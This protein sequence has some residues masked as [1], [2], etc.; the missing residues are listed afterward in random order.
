MDDRNE[1]NTKVIVLNDK[2]IVE[3][4]FKEEYQTASSAHLE[5]IKKIVNQLQSQGLINGYVAQNNIRDA[6]LL[7]A[8]LV[9]GLVIQVFPNE[10]GVSEVLLAIYFDSKELNAATIAN[11]QKVYNAIINNE[12]DGKPVYIKGALFS[13]SGDIMSSYPIEASDDEDNLAFDKII[14]ELAPTINK[15]RK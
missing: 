8:Q 15:G 13:P 14:E 4:G 1:K 3:E 11:F 7:V 5:M 2:M 9:N 12:I 10:V 6:G